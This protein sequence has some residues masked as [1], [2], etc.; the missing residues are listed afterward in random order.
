MQGL[1]ITDILTEGTLLNSVF[2]GSHATRGLWAV[3]AFPTNSTFGSNGQLLR[4]L[5]AAYLNSKY[6]GWS[7]GPYPISTAQVIAMWNQIKATGIYCAS[8]VGQCTNGGGMNSTQVIN[9]ISGMYDIAADIPADAD[10]CK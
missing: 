7:G 6:P 9:Y 4:H 8:G 1:A 5:S 2:P 10:L 3:L